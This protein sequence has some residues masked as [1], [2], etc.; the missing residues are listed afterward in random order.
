MALIYYMH[1]EYLTEI[2]I[3]KYLATKNIK[4]LKNLHFSRFLHTTTAKNVKY[5]LPIKTSPSLKI[6]LN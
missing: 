5:F 4:S 3:A 1:T 2:S 6:K